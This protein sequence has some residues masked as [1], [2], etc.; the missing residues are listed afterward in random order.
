MTKSI[1]R[2]LSVLVLGL[3]ATSAAAQDRPDPT[4]ET[5]RWQGQDVIAGRL[6]VEFA[7][8]TPTAVQYV[9]HE[10]LGTRTLAELDVDLTLV[11]LPRGTTIDAARA[12]YGKFPEVLS[13]E[14]DVLHHPLGTPD[15][16]KWGQQWGLPRV[17]A[18]A[19]WDLSHGDPS[20]VVAIIDSGCKTDHPDL[21]GH[22]AFGWDT[23]ADDAIPEDTDG[24]GTHCA[25]IAAAETDNGLGVAGASWGCR[26]AA[27]RAGNGSFPTSAL[28]SAIDRAVADGCQVLSM[29]WGSSYNSSAIR[30][31]LQDARDAGCV[32]VAAAGNDNSTTPFYPAGNAFVIAVASSAPNDTRSSFSNYGSW[33]DVAAPGQSIYSTWNNGGYT[34]LSGT[35]MACPLVAG[36]AT[37]LYSE[38]GGVRSVE[39]AAAVREALEST[40]EPVGNWVAYGRVDFDDAILALGTIDPPQVTSIS[41]LSTQVLGAETITL[42][43]SGFV[44]VTD[45]TVGDQAASDVVVTSDSQLTFTAPLGDALGPVPVVLTEGGQASTPISLTYDETD[46]PELLVEETVHV[47]GDLAWHAGGQVGQGVLLLIALSPSTFDFKGWPLL[48]DFAVLLS[49]PLDPVGRLDVPITL[50]PSLGPLT[51]YTQAVTVSGGFRGA[52]AVRTT[53][54]VP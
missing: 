10:A 25:G 18:E 21:D 47:G 32:L 49:S 51:F 48:T 45:V 46:P 43:G 23:Y 13:V 20:C 50:P 38:L 14:P 19:A 41:P 52:S 39:N 40:A 37:L 31:A 28:V 6:L 5:L 7:P 17:D 53:N 24:H 54:I 33:V 35:S 16:T 8:G 15:D 36:M 1:R 2:T 9:R 42:S 12:A 30:H 29:S 4:Y 44:G 26:F 22:Y 11:E 34:Y 27:Y 3:A